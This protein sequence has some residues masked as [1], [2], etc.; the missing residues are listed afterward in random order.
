M[1]QR[2]FDNYEFTYS[3]IKQL[4]L[5]NIDITKKMFDDLNEFFNSNENYIKDYII[6][7]VEDLS[8]EKNINFYYILLKYIFKNS[9]YIYNIPIL[10]NTRK[11]ILQSHLKMNLTFF[12]NINQNIKAKL[13]YII[14]ILFDSEYYFVKI[15]NKNSNQNKSPADELKNNFFEQYEESK[16][17]IIEQEYN[18]SNNNYSSINNNDKS[19]IEYEE[20]LNDFTYYININV[21]NNSENKENN[22]NEKYNE[23]KTNIKTIEKDDLTKNE[24]KK[25]YDDLIQLIQLI[26]KINE[27][28]TKE[29]KNKCEMEIEIHF[30]KSKEKING[31]YKNINCEYKSNTTALNK[32]GTNEIYQEKD[33]LN[34]FDNDKNGKY[35]E[36]LNS[37]LKNLNDKI[38]PSLSSI[39]EKS[40]ISFSK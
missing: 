33:I 34:K 28:I 35:L 2:K 24:D 40:N 4:E 22:K 21:I 16:R 20:Y 32:N 19:E 30:T 15:E 31:T 38:I 8:N 29:I 39:K 25:L 18:I 14:K 12:N 6:T 37:L 11:I 3:I 26:E 10:L 5:E 7:C 9:I 17:L 13:E 27:I 1:K 23:L 36:G